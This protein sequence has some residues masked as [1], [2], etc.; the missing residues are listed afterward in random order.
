MP[1]ELIDESEVKSIR[2][3]PK[4]IENIKLKIISKEDVVSCERTKHGMVNNCAVC[5]IL[6]KEFFSGCNNKWSYDGF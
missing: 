3:T 5:Q 6:N 2:E 1:L 4:K